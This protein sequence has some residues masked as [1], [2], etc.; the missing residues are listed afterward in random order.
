MASQAEI[1]GKIAILEKSIANFQPYS[2]P[3]QRFNEQLDALRSAKATAAVKVAKSPTAARAKVAAAAKAESIVKP[4]APKII[5]YERVYDGGCGFCA[6]AAELLYHSEDLMPVHEH[7]NC[8][9]QPVFEGTDVSDRVWHTPGEGAVDDPEL[10]AR[11]EQDGSDPL[12][13]TGDDLQ[14]LASE[15]DVD[16]E[17][18]DFIEGLDPDIQ[19]ALLEYSLNTGFEIN[20]GLRGLGEM[21]DELRSIVK[22]LDKTMRKID[23]PTL[24]H[25]GLKGSFKDIF[26]KDPEVGGRITDKGFISTTH[27]KDLA[28]KFMPKKGTMM[29]IR[30]PKGTRSSWLE[31]NGLGSELVLDRG[32]TLEVVEI[33]DDRIVMQ[34]VNDSNAHRLPENGISKVVKTEHAAAPAPKAAKKAVT[35]TA[36]SLHRLNIEYR[37]WAS[38][39]SDIQ[40]QALDDY[41]GGHYADANAFLRQFGTAYEDDSEYKFIHELDTLMKPLDSEVTVHRGIPSSFKSLFGHDPQVGGLIQDNA[42]MSTSLEDSTAKGFSQGSGVE[43]DITVPSGTPAAWL[44]GLHG[45]EGELLLN[46]GLNLQ[47]TSVSEGRVALRVLP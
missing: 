3:W 34:V 42:F 35:G 19:D 47:I 36:D 9:V 38:S 33:H 20:A 37:D 28:K 21:D 30:V 26:G 24:V 27:S 4:D 6:D 14:N 39:L 12:V 41:V 43:L 18:K 25:R 2:G 44:G 32:Q 11:L 13:F 16:A 23:R 1:D 40:R 29:D 7:C 45:H 22:D 15:S 10:G 31:D 8:G 46:R 17:F 5:G